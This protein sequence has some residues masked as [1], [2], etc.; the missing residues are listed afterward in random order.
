MEI[1]RL[2]IETGEALRWTALPA[3]CVWSVYRRCA[4]ACFTGAVLPAAWTRSAIRP[5]RGAVSARYMRRAGTRP[6]AVP[7]VFE[8]E[9]V[10]RPG[11]ETITRPRILTDSPALRWLE[12]AAL[13]GRIE[14]RDNRLEIVVSTGDAREIELCRAG[15]QLRARLDRAGEGPGPVALLLHGFG[16]CMSDAPENLLRRPGPAA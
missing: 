9:A 10:I 1:L 16:G 14:S 3:R 11:R 6:G 4:G 12:T 15:L 2:T 7:D 8:N 13:T 5:R